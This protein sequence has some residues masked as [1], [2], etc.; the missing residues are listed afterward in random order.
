LSSSSSLRHHAHHLLCAVAIIIFFAPS[1][2]SYL[3]CAATI[4]IFIFAPLHSTS[5]SPCRRESSLR[6]CDYHI[7]RAIAIILSSSRR[8][9]H[10]LHL[11]AIAIILSSSR[12]RANHLHL[13]AVVL[14]FIVVLCAHLIIAP[15]SA[16]FVVP[17][18]ASLLSSLLRR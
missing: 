16:Q 2:S 11:R 3:H 5:S 18:G 7:L 15:S 1:Q 17:L 14:I 13:R 12:R 10:H 8:R 9:A 6:R 4:S